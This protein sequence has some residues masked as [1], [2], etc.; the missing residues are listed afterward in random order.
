MFDLSNRQERPRSSSGCKASL[1]CLVSVPLLRRRRHRRHAKCV[2]RLWQDATYGPSGSTRLSMLHGCVS[3]FV[4]LWL[5]AW[6]FL[7]F[8][9]PSPDIASSNISARRLPI[10]S[11][12]SVLSTS[13]RN[14]ERIIQG[15]KTSGESIFMGHL[16]LS[17]GLLDFSGSAFLLIRLVVLRS[18]SVFLL[19]RRERPPNHNISQA[20]PQCLHQPHESCQRFSDTW[21]LSWL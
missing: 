17:L 13:K 14:P 20:Q 2:L 21:S 1:R 15:T 8:K 3:L 10:M 6:L 11:R 5:F 4:L 9:M 18:V 19:R 12:Y 7:H 16:R